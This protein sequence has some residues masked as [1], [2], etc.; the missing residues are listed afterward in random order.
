MA[1]M[2]GFL[3]TIYLPMMW[4][5]VV[6]FVGL[7]LVGVLVPNR[8]RGALR[9]FSKNTNIRLLGILLMLVGAEMFVRA[10]LIRFPLLVKTLGVLLFID[11]GVRLVIPTVSVI[12]AEWFLP[13]ADSLY[14]LAGLAGFGL[15]YLFYLATKLPVLV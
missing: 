13:R 10:S 8:L 12:I 9:F 1:A 6:V 11:G 14:R 15:A 4:I 3:E 2:R 7:G 5:L